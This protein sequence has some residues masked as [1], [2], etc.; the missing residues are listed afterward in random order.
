MNRTKKIL[1]ALL[2]VFIGMQLIQPA[3]N[4]SEHVISA[5]FIKYLNVPDNVTS[6]LKTSCYD[7]HSNYTSYPWYVN[8]QP[9]GWL[10]A[11]HIRDGKAEL[12]FNEFGNYSKRR[13][14]SKLKG[15][16]NSIKDGSMPLSSYTLLHQD[17]KLLKEGKALIM[18][19]TS[20]TADSLSKRDKAMIN[21]IAKM[22]KGYLIRVIVNVN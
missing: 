5:D 19:W 15:I 4:T 13:H 7:C 1:L 17:A 8:I 16:Y 3:R 12:N 6:I 22:K 2:I 9:I 20:K 10:L 11:R 21:K 14:L 18:D